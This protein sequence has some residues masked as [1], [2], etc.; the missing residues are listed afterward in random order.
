VAGIGDESAH[1]L[2]RC[3]GLLLGAALV[4]EG[5]LDL[6]EHAVEGPREPPDL[7]ALGPFGNAL[8]EVPVGDRGG[9]VL[10]GD[11]GP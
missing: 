4:G 11:Q 10:D 9:G 6:G 1:P 3:P 7:G 5:V 2:L 8:R